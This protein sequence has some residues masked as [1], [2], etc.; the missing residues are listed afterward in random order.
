MVRIAPVA[1]PLR[2]CVLTAGAALSAM[3]MQPSFAEHHDIDTE[4]PFDF[5]ALTIQE[6]IAQA[7]SVDPE[8]SSQANLEAGADQGNTEDLAKQAQNPIAS[9]ISFPIQWNATPGTQWAP[10][11]IDPSARD[12]RTQNVVNVQPVVPFKISN[13]LTLVTRTIVPIV[14]QPWADGVDFTAIGDINPSVFFVPTLMGNLTIGLGPTL[15]IPS[16]T[17]IRISSQRWSAGPSAVVVY[18]KGPWVLGGLANNVWSFSGRGGKDVN[19][20]LIQPFLN[21]NMPKGWYITSSPV[22]TNDWNAD[23]GKGWMVPIGAGIGRVFKIGN[24]PVNA[25][26]SA[27]W[28]AIRPEIFGEKLQG[29]FTIRTQVQ[30]L[31]PTGS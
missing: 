14:N 25:S 30:F 2:R 11:L 8:S 6:E 27:Y 3:V 7:D 1:L 17:D 29:E 4:Q 5:S 19:K 20:L 18:T 22:I 15:I 21:Y 23:D 13:D 16:A 10:S 26:L 31:F 24:Q 12:N 9:M 28:N